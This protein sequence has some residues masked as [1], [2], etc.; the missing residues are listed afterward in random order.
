M[1]A[2]ITL[3]DSESGGSVFADSYDAQRCG[4]HAAGWSQVGRTQSEV[5]LLTF[6]LSGCVLWWAWRNRGWAAHV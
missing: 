1:T 6:T 2:G 3:L 5:K 4:G